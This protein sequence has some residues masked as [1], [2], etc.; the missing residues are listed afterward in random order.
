MS[1]TVTS[2]AYKEE[3]TAT[4]CIFL[5]ISLNISCSNFYD[6]YNIRSLFSQRH[7]AIQRNGALIILLNM[8]LNQHYFI[9]ING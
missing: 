4:V 6:L 8:S 7:I 9:S 5:F 2:I 1:E 3:I